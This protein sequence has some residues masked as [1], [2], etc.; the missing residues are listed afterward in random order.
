M[1]IRQERISTGFDG[2]T[3]YCYVHARAGIAP[4]GRM[5]MTTQKLRLTGSDIFSGLEMLSRPSPDV[6]WSPITSSPNLTRKPWRD[7]M[8]IAMCDA[9][10][11]YHRATGKFLLLGHSVVYKDDSHVHELHPR[12]TTWSV[13]DD[14][15]NDWSPFQFLEMPEPFYNCGNGSGQSVELPDGTLLIPVYTATEN[16]M[17]VKKSDLFGS[18]V[19]HCAF[20]GKQL[21]LI[22][23]GNILAETSG[24]GLCEPSVVFHDGRFYMCL[25]NDA[26]S[27]VTTSDDGLHFAPHIEWLFDDGTPLGTYN[28]QQHWFTMQGK[29][30]LV[31][32]RR[33]ANNDHVFRHRAPLFF[34]EV[35][36]ETL[37]VI[38]STEQIAVPERGAR[39]GNF[40]CCQRSQ[41]EAFVIAAEW[42]QTTAPDPH[43]FRRCMSYGSDNSIWVTRITP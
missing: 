32:T 1:N 12:F 10:P 36:T 42:M 13:F 24:R 37:R 16:G 2:S 7:G 39:L 21:K 14:A 35:D 11:M 18:L 6:P 20:D 38:R 19:L 9:T 5:Q 15:A 33:G 25:R 22:E 30:Y 29:L 43:N 28:T 17:P 40:T 3:G 4:D 27:Y 34:A 23:F 41:D 8:E 31:Y 26:T